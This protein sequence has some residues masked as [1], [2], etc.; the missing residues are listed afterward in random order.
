MVV[1]QEVSWDSVSDNSVPIINISAPITKVRRN[2]KREEGNRRDKRD[3]EDKRN[4]ITI[5]RSNAGNIINERLIRGKPRGPLG[6][7]E[8]GPY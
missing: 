5:R 6:W 7:A 3:K 4:I 1:R 2:N 8:P